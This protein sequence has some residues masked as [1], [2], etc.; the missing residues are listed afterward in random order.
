MY[1]GQ[2]L[3]FRL[4]QDAILQK[5]C[6]C[7]LWHEILIERDG[8]DLLI[9]FNPLDGEPDTSKYEHTGTELINT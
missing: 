4:D 3:V 6:G 2:K 1:I 8:K 9:T 5:C 7:G